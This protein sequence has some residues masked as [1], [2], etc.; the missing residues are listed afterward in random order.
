MTLG[1]REFLTDHFPLLHGPRAR[2]GKG[3]DADDLADPSKAQTRAAARDAAGL[4]EPQ[5][6]ETGCSEPSSASSKRANGGQVLHSV[7]NATRLDAD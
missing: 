6:L 1:G 7:A 5:A 4:E 2:R 3:V